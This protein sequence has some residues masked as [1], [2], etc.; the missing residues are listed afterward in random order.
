MT[1]IKVSVF[2]D[3]KACE[4]AEALM[5]PL[6]RKDFRRVE[7]EGWVVYP[8]DPGASEYRHYCPK[9]QGSDDDLNTELDAI[10]GDYN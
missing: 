8:S 9:C 4:S 10:L 2:C 1:K 7:P 6:D 3:T 5:V